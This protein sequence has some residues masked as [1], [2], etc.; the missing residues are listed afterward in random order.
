MRARSKRMSLRETR[1]PA[2]APVC[3]APTRYRISIVQTQSPLQLLPRPNEAPA[4]TRSSTMFNTAEIPRKI[5][6]AAE[7]PTARS[8]QA[9]KL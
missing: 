7:L 4:H 3:T 6:G 1:R 9:K 2:Y 8:R 5:K